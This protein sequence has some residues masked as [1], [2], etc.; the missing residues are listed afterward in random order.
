METNVE[1]LNTWRNGPLA[2]IANI[3]RMKFPGNKLEDLLFRFRDGDQFHL[4]IDN[5]SRSIDFEPWPNGYEAEQN[6][7]GNPEWMIKRLTMDAPKIESLGENER[8]YVSL[9]DLSF[10]F[11]LLADNCLSVS[12]FREETHHPPT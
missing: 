10:R 9:S 3:A 8:S 6:Q 12:I 7:L 4:A 2:G 1:F 5:C 11:K